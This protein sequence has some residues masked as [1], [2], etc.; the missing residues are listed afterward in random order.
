ML[1]PEPY[2]SHAEMEAGNILLKQD[3][4]WWDQ[5][6]FTAFHIIR[7]EATIK[8]LLGQ[9]AKLSGTRW[10]WVVHRPAAFRKPLGDSMLYFNTEALAREYFEVGD[11]IY[12]KQLDCGTAEIEEAF[13]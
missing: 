11:L 4:K 2:T 9:I 3:P 5:A 8:M 7:L 10:I 13:K 12:K 1:K 6:A